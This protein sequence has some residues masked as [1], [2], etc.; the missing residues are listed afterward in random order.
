MYIC[1]FFYDRIYSVPQTGYIRMC[2]ILYGTRENQ[3]DDNDDDIHTRNS[4]LPCIKMYVRA[5]HF[6]AG[7]CRDAEF[8]SSCTLSYNI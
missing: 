8:N 5:N 6:N 4:L 7:A 1:V 2:C 3:R